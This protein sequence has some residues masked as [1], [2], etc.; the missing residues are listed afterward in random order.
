[1]KFSPSLKPSC[2]LQLPGAF[3]ALQ[4]HV[5]TGAA[6][7]TAKSTED[8]LL[9]LSDGGCLPPASDFYP[10]SVL[11]CHL[12]CPVLAHRWRNSAQC[13]LSPE[14]LCNLEERKELLISPELGDWHPLGSFPLP[15]QARWKVCFLWGNDS[16]SVVRHRAWSLLL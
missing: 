12:H 11:L 16:V 1:M 13:T 4:W 6:D 7:G 14:S 9:L 15:P 2:G 10:G 3:K 8:R 5:T